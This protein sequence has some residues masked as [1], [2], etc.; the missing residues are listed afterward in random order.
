MSEIKIHCLYDELVD[1]KTLKNHKDNRNKHPPEQIERLAKILEY[2]GWRYPIK[3]SKQTKS[4]TSGHGRKLAALDRGWKL[5]PVVYQDYES[6]E[7]EYADVQADNAIASWAELD[8]PGINSDIGLLGPDFDIDLLG[9][10]DFTVDPSEKTEEQIEKEILFSFK[11]EVEC[12]SEQN[13]QELTEELESRGFK[14][15]VLI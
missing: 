12:I 7:Q 5:V 9:I 13:Q 2:Q 10:K 3:I 6:E 15:R 11:I 14:V 4:I 8:L 1:P